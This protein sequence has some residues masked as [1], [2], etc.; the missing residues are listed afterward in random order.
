MRNDSWDPDLRA[1]GR[2]W[3]RFVQRFS[4]YLTNDIKCYQKHISDYDL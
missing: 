2:K 1:E 4:Q 3:K